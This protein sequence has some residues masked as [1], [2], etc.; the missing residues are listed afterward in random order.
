MTELEYLKQE[1]GLTDEEL[2]TA[3]A[4]LSGAK[5]KAFLK[6]SIDLNDNL[7]AANAAKTKAE[8]EL[9]QFTKRYNDEFVPAMQTVTKESLTVSGENA[10]LK[11]KL[12]KAKEY[13]IILEEETPPAAVKPGDPPRAS[14]SPDP[15]VIT[16]DEF[17]RFS[18][19][20]SN[21]IV[22]LA[23][24][25]AE[26]QT[27]FGAPLGNTQGL[28][29]EANRQRTLGNKNF[30]L[31]NAWEARENVAAKRAEVEAAKQKKHDDD[32]TASVLKAERERVGANPNLRSG[33]PS[34]YSTYKTSDAKVEKPWQAPRSKH[35][36]NADWRANAK[37]KVLAGAA[38]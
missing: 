8:T 7:T 36:R 29:D 1:S 5:F 26:H 28:V 2:K 32:L 13:G 6:K 35:E 38:A 3:E 17:G 16:R 23:D 22:A 4:L 37:A 15:N 12:A 30:T 19:S 27:L 34:R 18:Q 33:Q 21:V 24:L 14:G 11:A 20:Q 10:A 25:Q 9:G 31:R